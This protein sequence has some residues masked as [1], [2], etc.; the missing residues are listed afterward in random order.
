[1]SLMIIYSCSRKTAEKYSKCQLTLV[2]DL[3][4]V[5]V[6]FFFRYIINEVITNIGVINGPSICFTS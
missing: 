6:N 5:C 1:M 2:Y 3:Q 4:S